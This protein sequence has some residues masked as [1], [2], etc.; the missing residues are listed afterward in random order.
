MMLL[1]HLE[2]DISHFTREACVES[3]EMKLL[4]ITKFS[5]VWGV[6]LIHTSSIVLNVVSVVAGSAD[7]Q[8]MYARGVMATPQ[9]LVKLDL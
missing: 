4:S 9:L 5:P 2:M 8:M 6:M 3:I 1:K 7:C